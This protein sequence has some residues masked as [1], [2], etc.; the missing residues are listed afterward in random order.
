MELDDDRRR[1]VELTQ[2]GGQFGCLRPPLVVEPVDLVPPLRRERDGVG[3]GG[4]ARHHGDEQP[5][6]LVDGIERVGHP[7]QEGKGCRLQVAAEGRLVGAHHLLHILGHQVGVELRGSRAGDGRRAVVGVLQPVAAQVGVDKEG[8][9]LRAARGLEQQVAEALPEPLLVCGVAAGMGIKGVGLPLDGAVGLRLRHAERDGARGALLQEVL[10]AFALVEVAR[11]EPRHHLGQR[12]A[13]RGDGREP[14]GTGEPAGGGNPL[15]ALGQQVG[16]GEALRARRKLLQHRRGAVGRD[17]VGRRG[18][19]R[20][21]ARLLHGEAAAQQHR[22]HPLAAVRLGRVVETL[23]GVG[24]RAGDGAVALHLELEA[25]RP[26]HLGGGELAEDL[27]GGDVV[28]VDEGGGPIAHGRVEFERAAD[29]FGQVGGGDLREGD[30]CKEGCRIG[31]HDEEGVGDA[32]AQRTHVAIDAEG[33]RDLGA[34]PVEPEG[35]F[36][37]A[38]DGEHRLEDERHGADGGDDLHIDLPRLGGHEVVVAYRQGDGVVGGLVV[39]DHAAVERGH[40]GRLEAVGDAAALRGVCAGP[41]DE[42]DL[43]RARRHIDEGLGGCQE[44]GG[45]HAGDRRRE[46]QAA[47]DALGQIGDGFAAAAVVAGG[48]GAVGVGLAL[49]GATLRKAEEAGGAIGVDAAGGGALILE[50]P[51]GL[52]ERRRGL[53]RGGCYSIFSTTSDEQGD[54]DEPTAHRRP[55]LQATQ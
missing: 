10:E 14:V 50:H 22:G 4:P 29:L 55:Q 41:E 26:L 31:R 46:R 23:P 47:G 9:Q 44:L 33:E 5:V 54:T 53:K 30:R 20:L 25:K 24:H 52:S 40:G 8:A 2:L 13:R 35:T 28:G 3:G 51:A 7:A 34:E 32:R 16:G 36:V 42:G 49:G 48:R 39:D 15:V 1:P 19:G 11:K 12:L 43:G 6:A 45:A 18:R 17:G 27:R 38:C 37:A 21:V